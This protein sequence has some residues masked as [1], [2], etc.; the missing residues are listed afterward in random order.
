MIYVQS[1]S[2]C[3][4]RSLTWIIIRLLGH[5]HRYTVSVNSSFFGP[6][7]LTCE[8]RACWD[9]DDGAT[10]LQIKE[11]AR[12]SM[13]DLLKGL[14]GLA[15]GAAIVCN[16]P[17]RLWMPAER[18]T[19]QYLADASLQ[20]V[21]E[22]HRQFKVVLLHFECQVYGKRR[23]RPQ[24]TSTTACTISKQSKDVYWA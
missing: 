13:A 2:H 22:S 12:I 1:M 14:A 17:T 16:L 20:T 11:R 21:D 8:L 7:R 23:Y 6:E 24:T 5:W 3:V 10:R 18:A 9:G 4:H 15:V 19:L